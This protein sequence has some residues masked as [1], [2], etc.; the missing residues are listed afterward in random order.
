MAGKKCPEC[1]KPYERTSFT[2]ING[3]PYKM[4]YHDDKRECKQEF[5]PNREKRYLVDRVVVNDTIDS[6]ILL[7]VL[8]VYCKTVDLETI[9]P[10]LYFPN[11]DLAIKRYS[12]PEYYS[13]SIMNKIAGKPEIVIDLEKMRIKHEHVV[14]MVS[15]L[16]SSHVTEIIDTYSGEIN[17]KLRQLIGFAATLTAG[18]DIDAFFPVENDGMLAY[19]AV[20]YA[21]GLVKKKKNWNKYPV[22]ETSS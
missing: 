5:E 8:E 11:A 6:E 18:L 14:G 21:S 9:Y 16:Y 12:V 13:K 1:G 4:Y 19:W 15:G 22:F 7:A 2:S 10:D 17:L 3:I 20:K